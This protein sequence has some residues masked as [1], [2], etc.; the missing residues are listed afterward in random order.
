LAVQIFS[1]LEK[2]IGRFLPLALLFEAQ[3]VRELARVLRDEKFQADWGSLVAIRPNGSRPPFFCIHAIGGLVV[4]YRALAHHLG[5]GYPFYGLQ[6]PGLNQNKRFLLSIE[7][8]ASHYIQE[9]RRIQPQG[10][11]FL[12]GMSFGGRVAFEMARQL[13]QN[14]DSVALIALFDTKAPGYLK[15][16]PRGEQYLRIVKNQSKRFAVHALNLFRNLNRLDYIRTGL[17]TLR[18]RLR[19]NNLPT[20]SLSGDPAEAS[21]PEVFIRARE[22]NRLASKKY[23]PEPFA[24]RIHLFRARKK[25]SGRQ[26][27]PTLGWDQ[28]A[29]GGIE[30]VDVPG[31]HVKCLREP[32]VIVT[33][34]KLRACIDAVLESAD[35]VGGPARP[36]DAN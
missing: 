36:K 6:L 8:L 16:L 9:I 32:H 15:T 10:P 35:Y 18:W 27:N 20:K 26:H 25:L 33:A 13:H 14:G 22:L 1:R 17:Q 19:Y 11:Y 34:A 21:I 23:A 2:I 12:G 29:K 30:I 3:T 24:G 28:Y 5:G 7:Q 31:D 4:N